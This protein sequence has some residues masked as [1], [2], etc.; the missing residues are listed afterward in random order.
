[1]KPARPVRPGEIRKRDPADRSFGVA[2]RRA[3]LLCMSFAV[4]MLLSCGR[5]DRDRPVKGEATPATAELARPWVEERL[6]TAIQARGTVA[7]SEWISVYRA[8]DGDRERYITVEELR[9]VF[10]SIPIR[11]A[12]GS[13]SGEWKGRVTFHALRHRFADDLAGA[14]VSDWVDGAGP[15]AAMEVYLRRKKSGAVVWATSPAGSPPVEDRHFSPDEQDVVATAL[16]SF[17]NPATPVDRRAAGRSILRVLREDARI[18]RE[19]GGGV[20]K[21]ASVNARYVETAAAMDMTGCPPGFVDAY[22][23][24]LEAWRKGEKALI[25]ST[26]TPVA[27][28]ANQNGVGTFQ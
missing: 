15:V 20:D 2:R 16:Q 23:V 6:R 18:L 8:P 12:G 26:W 25:E 3:L 24:H 9:P 19:V 7:G 11:G 17:Q 1:M 4:P 28:I 21:A 27:A 5:S 13:G 22:R 10:E 14:G